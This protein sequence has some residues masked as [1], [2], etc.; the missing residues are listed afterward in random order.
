M[1]DPAARRQA[2]DRYEGGVSDLVVAALRAEGRAVA[3]LGRPD[4]E[5]RTGPGADFL[6]TVDGHETA[7][8][9]TRTASTAEQRKAWLSQRLTQR[10]HEEL[11]A[12]VEAMGSGHAVVYFD[13]AI[14]NGQP[15]PRRVVD[16]VAPAV[17]ERLRTALPRAVEMRERL[18]LEDVGPV[19]D[20]S[21]RVSPTA[22]HQLSVMWG[23]GGGFIS[24]IADAV[25]RR[26]IESKSV[27]LAQYPLAYLALLEPTGLLTPANI[28][29][30]FERAVVPANWRRVYV[31][32]GNPPAAIVAWEAR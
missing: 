5:D 25:V 12:E 20:L 32:A 17:V 9:I 21:L 26:V 28:G 1:M 18:E 11:D 29:E 10:M 16:D 19:V 15:P 7:L 22:T 13:L 24:P 27:Q 31:I 3:M 6:L 30:A 4:R 2:E 8:E 23:V 14:A